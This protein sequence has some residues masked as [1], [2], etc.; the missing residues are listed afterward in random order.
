MVALRDAL[1]PVLPDDSA[2]AALAGRVWL[3][4]VSG[5]AIVAVRDGDLLD[6]TASFPTI[7]DLC[8]ADAPADRLRATSGERIGRLDD[9]LAN[10]PRDAR[11]QRT[12]W[13]LAPIDL[14]PSRPPA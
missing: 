7:R 10:T 12:P 2:Q 13:L 8:E 5:P 6:I 11:D 14:R 1:Q 4:D 9:V 3:P